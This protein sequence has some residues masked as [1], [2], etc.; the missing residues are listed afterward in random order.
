MNTNNTTP[1]QATAAAENFMRT[2]QNRPNVSAREIEDGDF[3]RER[4]EAEAFYRS[5]EG[6]DYAIAAEWMD[7]NPFNAEWVDAEFLNSEDPRVIAIVAAYLGEMKTAKFDLNTT[8]GISNFR[9]YAAT[10]IG[11]SFQYIIENGLDIE[12]EDVADYIEASKDA[13]DGAEWDWYNLEEGQTL[14]NDSQAE[15]EIFISLGKAAIIAEIEN[16]PESAPYASAEINSFSEDELADENGMPLEREDLFGEAKVTIHK[17]KLGYFVHLQ[18]THF[19]DEDNVEED[20]V[21][22]FE[23]LD[24]AEKWAAENVGRICLP[25]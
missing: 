4:Y 6:E 20:E 18:G 21:K 22:F 19:N 3:M 14:T 12:G 24:E 16:N 10:V 15:R 9:Q 25:S 13:Y 11:N 5:G 1:A 8:E 17:Y 2:Y 7:D 23:E